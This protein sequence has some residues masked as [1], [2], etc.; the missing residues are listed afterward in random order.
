MLCKAFPGNLLPSGSGFSVIAVGINGNA[1][2]RRK[3]SP[4]LNIFRIHKT[5]QILHNDVHAILMKISVIA[6]AEKIQLQRFALHHFFT[7]YVGYR[8]RREIWL[9]GN[10][11]KACKFRTV[12]FYKVI[13]VRMLVQ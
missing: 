10:G 13:V 3:F 5:D 11:T 7:G 12:K 1:A 4:D 2:S 9:S 6:E 8:D